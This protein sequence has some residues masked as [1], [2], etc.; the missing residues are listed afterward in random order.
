VISTVSPNQEVES[1]LL[2]YNLYYLRNRK[3]AIVCPSAG[4]KCSRLTKKLNYQV[5]IRVIMP[6]TSSQ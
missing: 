1:L 2:L 5:D 3:I 6:F 4:N